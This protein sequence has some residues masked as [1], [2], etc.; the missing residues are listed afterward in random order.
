MVRTRT[1]YMPYVKAYDQGDTKCLSNLGDVFLSANLNGYILCEKVHPEN[2]STLPEMDLVTC[3][4]FPDPVIG[5]NSY[6]WLSYLAN[7]RPGIKY[8]ENGQSHYDV[9]DIIDIE[10]IKMSMAKNNTRKT[11]D[12]IITTGN[13]FYVCQS[14]DGCIYLLRGTTTSPIITKVCKGDYATAY[15]Q[16]N[17]SVNIYVRVGKNTHKYKGIVTSVNGNSTLETTYITQ[18]NNCEVVF[19]LLNNKIMYKSYDNNSWSIKELEY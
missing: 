19:E 6:V 18:I 12:P 17:G 10:F 14:K 5:Q 15:I 2:T 13:S 16:P 1:I 4:Y 8:C 3:N 7:D 9:N 11:G